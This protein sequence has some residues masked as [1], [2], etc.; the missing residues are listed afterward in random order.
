MVQV[1]ISRRVPRL[2]PRWSRKVDEKRAQRRE[3]AKKE[4]EKNQKENKATKQKRL[5]NHLKRKRRPSWR[6]KQRKKAKA[7]PKTDSSPKKR[8][9]AKNRRMRRRMHPTTPTN[10]TTSG[11]KE[12]KQKSPPEP[13]LLTN[14]VTFF[15]SSFHFIVL[16]PVSTLSRGLGLRLFLRFKSRSW[17]MTF[18]LLRTHSLTCLLNFWTFECL[19]LI[20]IFIQV[21][22]KKAKSPTEN[23]KKGRQ[24]T[25]RRKTTYSKGHLRVWEFLWSWGWCWRERLSISVFSWSRGFLNFSFLSFNKIQHFGLFASL[26]RV[27]NEDPDPDS[28]FSR[29]RQSQFRKHQPKINKFNNTKSQIYTLNFWLW[30]SILYCIC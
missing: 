19:L 23:I 24:R 8:W 29:G 21:I 6:Q 7:A 15:L 5:S 11:S 22:Y 12:N 13:S 1:P 18:Y 16:I 14:D 10:H 20:G 4:K 30:T 9:M 3:K 25:A 26:A 17:M 28:R 27:S 2:W